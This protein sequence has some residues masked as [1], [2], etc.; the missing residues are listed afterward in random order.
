[1]NTNIQEPCT[2]SLLWFVSMKM[3]VYVPQADMMLIQKILPWLKQKREAGLTII[4]FFIFPS[5][6]LPSWIIWIKKQFYFS[7]F[8]LL[9]STEISLGWYYMMQPQIQGWLHNSI[10]W[11][12]FFWSFQPFVLGSL[13]MLSEHLK[14]SWILTTYN[15]T[16]F[17][18]LL[19]FKKHYI[20]A[21]Q[22]YPINWH[23]KKMTKLIIVNMIINNK[24]KTHCNSWLI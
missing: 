10:L 2:Y 22:S 13:P 21:K 20:L 9:L 18:P 3:E 4:F 7:I 6:Y 16:F 5:L 17:F 8:H 23:H 1:M 19:L 15:K 12:S 24:W 14:H 11:I